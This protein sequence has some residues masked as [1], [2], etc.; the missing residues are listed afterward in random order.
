MSPEDGIRIVK[1]ND[2]SIKLS[3]DE[4][5]KEYIID[6]EGTLTDDTNK[7]SDEVTAEIE[8]APLQEE[9]GYTDNYQN[10]TAMT[11]PDNDEPGENVVDADKGVPHGTEKPW[12]GNEGN[13]APYEENVNE[14]ENECGDNCLYEIEID[15]ED[16]ASIEEQSRFGK[17]NE[18]GMHK[19][20]K[21]S[22][23]ST[24]YGA[25]VISREG[26]YTGTETGNNVNENLRRKAEVI[27]NENKEL[28]KIAEDLRAKINEAVVINS[29]LA[30]VINLVT[31][32]STT[33][34]EKI[35]ILQRFNNVKTIN[36]SKELYETISRELKNA[37][38]VNNSSKLINGQ[39]NES[40]IK[41]T[42]TQIYKS[43]DLDETRA[44]MKRLDAI[45]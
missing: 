45:K 33:R 42:E 36:E 11:T 10:Q 6:I 28:R 32:N 44:F 13:V 15:T 26:E 38:T 27:F 39:L 29:S 17:A 43:D 5:E 2:G 3:D 23:D 31:E 41:A 4:T 21:S 20:P 35:D 24:I 8:I 40:K 16:E 25:H 14:D 19:T 30:K 7:A 34:N 12:V 22:N 37:H 1:N 9:L 18:K